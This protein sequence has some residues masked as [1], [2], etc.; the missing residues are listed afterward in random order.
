MKGY[1]HF[2][3]LT[4]LLSILAVMFESKSF[5]I[6]L[7][8]WL[9]YLYRSKKISKGP[10]LLSLLFFICFYTYLPAS[11]PESPDMLTTEQT[12]NGGIL[13]TISSPVTNSAKKLEF[14]VQEQDSNRK[15]NVITFKPENEKWEPLQLKQLKY[16]ATC[17]ME[18]I[19]ELPDSSR[20]PGQFD[21]RS[22]LQTKGITQQLTLTSLEKI[23]CEGSSYLHSIFQTR[24][25]LINFVIKKT[26]PYTAKW[27]TALV[28]GD[29][30][31]LDEKTVE[32]F[33]KW[34]L[35]HLLAIS[36]LHVGL[37]IAIIYFLLIKLGLLTREKAQWMMLLIL[38][39][40]AFIA[41]GEPSVW[42]AC[43]MV[44]VFIILHK[45]KVIYSLTDVLSIIFLLLI[46]FD[47][48]IIYHVGFQL[49]FLVTLGLLL[50]GK[51]MSSVK[52]PL[53]ISLQISFVAQMMI[54][55]LQLAYF[56]TFQP[57][58]ILLN[59][60]VVPYFSIFVIPFMFFILLL[61]PLPASILTVFNTIFESIHKAFIHL[62]QMIDQ[63]GY[64]PYILGALPLFAVV[65]YYVFF[66][67]LMDAMQR[68]KNKRAMQ[69][70][71]LLVMLITF[72]AVKPYLSPYGTVTML[73]IG[74]GDSFVIELPYRKAVFF[75]DAGAKMSFEKEQA[76]DGTYKQVIKPYLYE[77]GITKIDALFL[78]HDDVDHVGSVPFIIEDMKV[79]HIFLSEFYQLPAE[80]TSKWAGNDITVKRLK[81]G[82]EID[83]HD[84]TIQILSPQND[85][86]ESNANSLVM[87]MKL[88]GLG[89]LFT[90]DSDKK[91]EKEIEKKYPNLEFNVLK[92][93]HHG[94]N[95]AT[96][97]HFVEQYKPRYAWISVGKNN[98]YGHPT[99]NVL[100]VLRDE[101][102]IIFR[103]DQ[104]GAVQYH[105]KKDKGTF[106]KYIP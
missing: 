15:I 26:D 19:M 23:T 72:I 13:G 39:F 17:Q 73:D 52:S 42:R 74:Q 97:K 29:D 45:L 38:P 101:G 57:L 66:L 76:T 95:S 27:L 65:I 37:I 69:F 63:I 51:W 64:F 50:S 16:G 102:M 33:Q 47:K 34:N 35:S 68:G 103:T 60:I 89:W 82:N 61:S 96:D 12:I 54:I 20:N 80:T 11:D 1:W 48:Y 67:L 93:A 46:L 5:I 70:G 77:N 75:I 24:I 6:I 83:F 4:V 7:F 90:G 88:G 22:Y 36:G 84:Y 30:S 99:K 71:G 56:S 87:Y 8:L 91:V 100:D 40:Y 31:L 55:P 14:V 98:S 3:A 32:L 25:D 92:V 43:L 53:M 28:L 79:D 10:L 81:A 49:S 94:S 41:G 58:S 85:K 62:L 105:F 78:S 106:S 104:D 2:F 9:F 21:Y 59:V 86:K 44:L 18:G